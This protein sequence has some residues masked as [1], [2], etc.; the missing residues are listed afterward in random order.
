MLKSPRD[1]RAMQI[2]SEVIAYRLSR[3][4]KIDVPPCHVAIDTR[5]GNISALIEFFYQYPQ[6]TKTVRLVHGADLLNMVRRPADGNRPH[7]VATNARALRI[8]GIRDPV[9]WWAKVVTFDALI[10]NTDRH[11]E[12]WGALQFTEEDRHYYDFT[13]AYD[14]GT[15][16]GYQQSEPELIRFWQNP[17]RHQRF[18]DGGRH[19][20]GL[21]PTDDGPMPHM[22]L[23]EKFLSEYPAAGSVM[24]SVI[25]ISDAQIRQIVDDCV[26]FRVED[27]FSP[28]R[29]LFVGAQIA[30]RRDRLTRIL[31]V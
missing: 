23:C 9:F 13:P 31:G 16:L 6:T 4:V 27:R 28:E 17:D 2:W 7:D 18:I 12:N 8:L 24:R 30:A 19:D 1:W 29:A 3:I 20:C 15:S 21:S 11:T 14:N 5:T 26:A 10:G 25:R 22:I